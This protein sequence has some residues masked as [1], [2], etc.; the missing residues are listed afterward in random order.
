MVKKIEEPILINVQKHSPKAENAREL[1]NDIRKLLESQAFAVLAT[2]GKGITVASLVT[3]DSS[4]DLKNIVFVTPRNSEKF[5][6]ID[7]D[8]NIS[9]LVDD[10]SMHQDSINEISALTI[11]GKA[12]IL[13]NEKEI[14]EW[15]ARLT[16]KHPNLTSFVK[17]PTSAV[18]LVDV[19][20]YQ[21][22]KKFQEVWEWDPS[23][24]YTD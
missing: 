14:L 18:I 8:E 21:Y 19:V 24:H 16:R 5:N 11:I 12:R 7:R 10:R 13:S 6:L 3:F 15:G 4:I 20:R 22:V 23:N 1:E 17:A 2:Q 9:I